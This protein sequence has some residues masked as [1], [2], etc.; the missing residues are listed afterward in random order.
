M[1][2]EY[3]SYVV[4]RVLETT[5]ITWESPEKGNLMWINW[6]NKYDCQQELLQTIIYQLK[7]QNRDSRHQTEM[8]V[9]H[10]LSDP[11]LYELSP[12]SIIFKTQVGLDCDCKFLPK[13]QPKFCIG[14]FF[15]QLFSLEEV[16]DINVY[17]ISCWLLANY[18]YRCRVCC[19]RNVFSEVCKKVWLT[20][21]LTD[22]VTAC[23]FSRISVTAM[24]SCCIFSWNPQHLNSGVR[25]T[26]LPICLLLD[27]SAPP[28]SIGENSSLMIIQ[29]ILSKYFMLIMNQ[30][31]RAFTEFQ[32][33]R[34][35]PNIQL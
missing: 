10:Y 19:G 5:Y 12:Q 14:S 7:R 21:T 30:K 16:I 18:H 32:L 9:S 29:K 1:F 15:F 3:N 2:R 22:L 17:L 35:P 26:C 6:P 13:N 24:K 33:W 8:W 20:L 4:R 34:N 28:R 23:L 25:P 27:F 11:S 31:G